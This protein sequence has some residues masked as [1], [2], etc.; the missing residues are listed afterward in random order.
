MISQVDVPLDSEDMCVDPLF[1]CSDAEEWDLGPPP[2]AAEEVHS[3]AHMLQCTPLLH[4]DVTK[5]AD[6]VIVMGLIIPTRSTADSRDMTP[7]Y[8]I[9]DTESSQQ[10]LVTPSVENEE[11]VYDWNHTNKN[12]PGM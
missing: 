6:T 10:D 3:V 5:S 4:K 1:Q 7:P 8:G 11:G 2:I 12:Y 9:E